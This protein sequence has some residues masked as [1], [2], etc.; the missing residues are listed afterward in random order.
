MSSVAS[1]HHPDQESNRILL[2]TLNACQ[3]AESAVSHAVNGLVDGSSQAFTLV[4][5][6]EEQLDQFDHD[7]DEGVTQAVAG[8]STANAR[9]LLACM[10]LMI[11]LE[12]IGDLVLSFSERAAVVR[13]RIEMD[14]LEALTKMAS[15]LESMLRDAREAFTHRDIDL[16]LDVLRRDAEIDRFRNLIVIRH[17]EASDAIKGPES[18]HVI[19]MAQALERAGDHG[20]K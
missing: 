20:K 19:S 6:C 14:D 18:L 11:D 12:R 7:I 4:R 1:Q 13:T 16:A 8:V 2:L 3:L 5:K 9:Q 17:T 15:I 10:K